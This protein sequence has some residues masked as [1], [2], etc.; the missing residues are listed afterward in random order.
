MKS[1]SLMMGFTHHL[2]NTLQMLY[3][4]VAYYSFLNKYFNE[5]FPPLEILYRK[6]ALIF[7]NN[8]FSVIIRASASNAIDIAGIHMQKPNTLPEVKGTFYT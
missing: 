8:H 5:N 3:Y 7:Y 6:V 2:G 1:Y 4:F